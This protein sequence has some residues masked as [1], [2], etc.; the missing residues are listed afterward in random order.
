LEGF[1]V[2]AHALLGTE[3]GFFLGLEE[4]LALLFTILTQGED[5][6][7]VV[8]VTTGEH[9]S[10]VELLLDEDTTSFLKSIETL[11]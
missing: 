6:I 1:A 3:A 7:G 4:L 11:L 10:K 8:L 9:F 2:T 5:L